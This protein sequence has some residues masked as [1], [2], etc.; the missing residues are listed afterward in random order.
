[1]ASNPEETVSELTSVSSQGDMDSK[2]YVVNVD[3]TDL[4]KIAEDV[5]TPD[6]GVG[7]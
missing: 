6:W 1:M 3:G 4:K 7:Q 2:L 5:S